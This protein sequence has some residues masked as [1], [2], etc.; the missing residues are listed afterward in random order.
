MSRQ[1][2]GKSVSETVIRTIVRDI[3]S[4]NQLCSIATVAPRNRAHINTAFFA[5][6]PNFEFYFLSDPDSL[7]CRNL[8][9]NPSLAMTIFDSRQRWQQAGRGLQLFGTC[10]RTH[11]QAAREAAKVYGSRFPAFGRWLSSSRAF[12]RRQARLLRAYAF[13]RFLPTKVKILDE[14]RF[15]GAVFVIARIRR[16]TRRGRERT[17]LDW[18]STERFVP[19]EGSE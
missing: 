10:R 17:T 9:A 11:G 15:G 16:S 6:S 1:R 8:L 13:F 14:G 19:T 5:Y 12:E 7:H 18:Q 2:V 3:L 4:S